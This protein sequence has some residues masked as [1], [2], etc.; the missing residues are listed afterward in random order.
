MDTTDN[1]PVSGDTKESTLENPVVRDKG[2]RF[3]K[4]A[5]SGN[6]RGRPRENLE[7][8]ELARAQGPAAIRR[9]TQLMQSDDPQV[10]IAASKALLDRG[11][12]RPEQSIA[13]DATV[14]GG[15]TTAYPSM[16]DM[17]PIDA[18]R[19]YQELMG[20]PY[21][22]GRTAKAAANITFGEP[23]HSP[24]YYEQQRAAQLPAPQE[25]IARP[26][27]VLAA[28][29]AT[30]PL[31][32]GQEKRRAAPAPRPVAVDPDDPSVIAVVNKEDEILRH[33][34]PPRVVT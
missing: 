34:R 2:G 4:G 16:M 5:G 23:K 12:G 25:P 33:Q 20:G 24:E 29:R 9:L 10:C 6:P 26:P 28:P 21:A 13:L 1:T 32:E 31:P 22:A 30:E 17:D 14:T 27:P 19:A 7:V 11:F 18:A 8:K 15:P 3:V